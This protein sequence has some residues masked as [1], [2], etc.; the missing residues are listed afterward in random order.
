MSEAKNIGLVTIC[1]GSVHKS[2]DGGEG[3]GSN[4]FL[5]KASRNRHEGGVSKI[6]WNPQRVILTFL[7]SEIFIFPMNLAAL[8]NLGWIF[9]T[10][11]SVWHKEI[12][13]YF[14]LIFFLTLTHV[15]VRWYWAYVRT[16]D[17]HRGVHKMNQE[18][19]MIQY[20]K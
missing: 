9:K 7:K 11:F 3:E 8:I 5:A 13:L 4:F 1:L 17:S 18:G 19:C 15:F 20:K 12:I 14:E 6:F 16:S 10:R 2:R